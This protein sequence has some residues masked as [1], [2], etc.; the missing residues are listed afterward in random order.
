MRAMTHWLD[1]PNLSTGTPGITS[2]IATILALSK[3]VLSSLDLADVLRRVLI[4]TRELT[5]ADVVSIWLLDERGE[6]LTSAATLGLE[7]RK[8]Q[9][10]NFR[11]RVGEGVAGWASPI[12]RSCNLSIQL[13]I[14][15]TYSNL[16]ATPQ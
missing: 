7:E 16:I 12:V 3:T 9:D 14:R 8:E 6:W 4:A 11:L 13:M 10:R 2:P 5:G 1:S 15:A